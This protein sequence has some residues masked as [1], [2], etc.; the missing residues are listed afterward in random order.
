MSKLVPPSFG[1]Y[2][3]VR[4]VSILDEATVI[5]DAPNCRR[6]PKMGNIATILEV[7]QDPYGFELECCDA[8]GATIWLGGYTPAQLLL[9]PNLP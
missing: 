6:P 4:V 7:Y 9:E 1:P 2:D 5:V 8:N 3:V